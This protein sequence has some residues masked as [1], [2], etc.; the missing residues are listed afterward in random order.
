MRA[1]GRLSK[2]D[3][4]AAGFR[5]LA[6]QGPA[7]LR[8]EALARGLG[9]TKGSFYWHFADVPAF[10]SEMLS[11]WQI[12]VAAEIIDMVLAEPDPSERLRVMARE[13]V[14]PPPPEFGGRATEPAMRA[15]ALVDDSVMT[16]LISLDQQR[17]MFLEQL[18]TDIGIKDPAMAQVLYAAYL[19]LDD[20]SAKHGTD[21]A[22][23]MQTLVD[24]ILKAIPA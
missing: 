14:R 12:K 18:L 17:L 24:L 1:P 11:L 3:W 21:M 6:T 8:A 9:T 22:P 13:A 5:A 2:D 15:W 20:L 23:P 4:L 7:A 16:A 10:K 19:G